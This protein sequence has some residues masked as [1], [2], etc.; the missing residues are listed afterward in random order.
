M[1]FRFSPTSSKT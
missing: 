1:S